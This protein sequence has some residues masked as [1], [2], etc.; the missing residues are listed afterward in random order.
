MGERD[1][2]GW[3]CTVHRNTVRYEDNP[4]ATKLIQ[5]QLNHANGL[6]SLV[7]MW[8]LLDEA[9]FDEH[10]KWISSADRKE[11]KAWKHLRHTGCHAPGG[12]AHRYKA[13]F[14][15]F[16]QSGTAT[17]ALKRNCTYTEN[18]INLVDGVNWFFFQF[19]Q[20][21]IKKA[22]AHCA[23]DNVPD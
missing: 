2:I 4:E 6:V 13:E 11:L 18:S 20:E 12:R 23:N 7:Y 10:N 17:S 9:E 22:I 15:D 5:E 1:M 19:A 21:L 16:M 8:A 3:L 14:N